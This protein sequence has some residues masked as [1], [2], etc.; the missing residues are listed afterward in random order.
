MPTGLLIGAAVAGIGLQTASF[1]GG[2]GAQ[3]DYNEAQQKAM[4]EQ[5]QQEALKQEAMRIDAAR[6]QTENLRQT[7]RA[8]SLAVAA[9]ANQ[10]ALGGSGLQGGFAQA[11]AQGNWNALGIQQNLA[12]GEL[13]FQSNQ[14]LSQDKMDMA[15]AQS[16]MSFW[17]GLGSL[18][19][20]LMSSSGTM[21]NVGK[22]LFGGFGSSG[23]T[24]GM[25]GPTDGGYYS[26]Y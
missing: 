21:G 26:K 13:M 2:Q 6:K 18:G 12:S 25:V 14:R 16:E 15:D 23:G 1:L 22:N 9:A 7:Q 10:G 4:Q 5:Q 24:G 19:G 17:S 8:R 3:E 20:S 11:L